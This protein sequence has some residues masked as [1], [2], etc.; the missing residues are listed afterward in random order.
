MNSSRINKAVNDIK[1]LKL[2]Q[3]AL[4]SEESFISD[5]YQSS[6]TGTMVLTVFV[7]VKD[8]DRIKSL[9]V[10][11]TME[12]IRKC[13]GRKTTGNTHALSLGHQSIRLRQQTENP[14]DV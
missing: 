8:S 14:R 4:I 11:I 7:P 10:S 1:K 12:D 6:E 13:G 2:D 9:Y 5:P 3:Q